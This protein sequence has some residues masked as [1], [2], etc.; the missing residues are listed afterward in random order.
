[1]DK[2][3]KTKAMALA[4]GACLLAAAVT[5]AGI[6]DGSGQ[7]DPTWQ[8]NSM[9]LWLKPDAGITTVGGSVSLWADQSTYGNDATQATAAYQP[10]HNPTGLNGQPA[11]LFDGNDRH[12]IIATPPT[13][14]QTAFFVYE[15]ASTQAWVTP[16]GTV[17][18]GKGAYHGQS[19]DTGLFNT[20][21]T[22]AKTRNGGNYRNGI[23]IGNGTTTPRPD[24]WAIDVHV[25]TGPL[26]QGARTVGADNGF[27]TSRE[28]NGGIAEIIL[29]DRPLTA[30]EVDQVGH[31]LETKYSI[32]TT[33]GSD[34]VSY[35]TF[36]GGT[37]NDTVGL[38]HGTDG[39]AVT[40]GASGIIGQA[41][42]FQGQPGNDFNANITVPA[43]HTLNAATAVKDQIT[44][45]AWIQPD[46]I[47][48]NVYTE[49]M[50]QQSPQYKFLSFQD[51]G[52]RFRFQLE[53]SYLDVTGLNPADF[54]DGNWHHIA[55]TYDGATQRLY[56]DGKEVASKAVAMTL[57][58]AAPPAF[59]I[60][61]LNLGSTY[62]EAFDGRI[63][64]V[65]VWDGA[66]SADEVK[67]HWINRQP[68]TTR[69]LP[70]D[71]THW[72]VHD[73]WDPTDGTPGDPPQR[74]W[75]YQA[76]DSGQYRDLP[77]WQTYWGG[78]AWRNPGGYPMIGPRVGDF[79]H[80][81][82]TVDAYIVNNGLD[83]MKLVQVHPASPPYGSSVN[84]IDGVFTWR[85]PLPGS[86][87][88]EFDGVFWHVDDTGSDGIIASISMSE[89]FG[90]NDL[91][92]SANLTGLGAD[93]VTL[94]AASQ[95]VPDSDDFL[96]RLLLNYGDEVHFR[97]NANS[98]L[99][100][101]ASMFGCT[102]TLIPEPTTM[103]LLVGG[104]GAMAVRRRRRR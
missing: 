43:G 53:G 99:W 85:N 11:V 68:Y 56:F 20:T 51:H 95:T 7:P 44:L 101:D 102:V 45:E 64:E 63:D 61:N 96:F 26:S 62:S 33:Y 39:S 86:N 82:A 6:L 80:I 38:N 19:N 66:L 17:Y 73:D 31:Y 18:D 42:D 13:N 48:T 83:Q 100:S 37:S 89:A 24:D 12:M 104:L 65:A 30:S 59:V 21:Y 72:N 49:V 40:Q 10:T 70:N 5:R 94:N 75:F 41:V 69:L 90:L 9:L 29:Y 76:L 71:T 77:N 93:F 67:H 81:E 50:R 15:D 98:A 52:T 54:E 46:D 32:P 74:A 78:G 57:S 36:D 91:L 88:F 97:V 4:L 2:A 8:S 1:M 22:D 103:M 16:L 55:G 3:A 92:L 23:N 79:D 34:L 58:S 35:W 47:S 84:K 28:I 27:G 87:V 25:A 14:Y 60:G